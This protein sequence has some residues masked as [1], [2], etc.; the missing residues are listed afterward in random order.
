MHI[1]MPRVQEEPSMVLQAPREEETTL[2]TFDENE[3]LS[4]IP[5]LNESLDA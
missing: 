5:E 1:V 2:N 3:Q 4:S